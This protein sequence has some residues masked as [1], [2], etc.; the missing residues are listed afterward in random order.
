MLMQGQ[1]LS[2]LKQSELI[3]TLDRMKLHDPNHRD[4]AA[5]GELSLLLI[6]HQIVCRWLEF[7][8]Q[9]GQES[10]RLCLQGSTF[11]AQP[12]GGLQPL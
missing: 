1:G 8:L 12:I 2:I 7:D 11:F 5:T 10:Q 9:T 6:C 3:E 4:V